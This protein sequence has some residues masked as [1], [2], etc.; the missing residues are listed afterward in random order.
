MKK[1]L[2]ILSI[3]AF[4]FIVGPAQANWASDIVEKGVTY[5]SIGLKC[6]DGVTVVTLKTKDGVCKEYKV[7]NDKVTGMRDCGDADWSDFT[8]KGI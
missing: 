1:L 4:L 5:S 2:A 3:L 6:V 7:V 8:K